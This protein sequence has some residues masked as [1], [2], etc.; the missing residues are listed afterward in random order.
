M[1]LGRQFLSYRF[2]TKSGLCFVRCCKAS[3][4]DV[5]V[6]QADDGDRII[7]T[8]FDNN[9]VVVYICGSSRTRIR[10]HAHKDEHMKPTPSHNCTPVTSNYVNKGVFMNYML[11]ILVNT[12]DFNALDNW[13]TLTFISPYE[14]VVAMNAC[15]LTL[16]FLLYIKFKITL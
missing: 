3:L 15:L 5:W 1:K 6:G 11:D 16:L 9:W 2:A 10:L 8:L 4:F 12:G 14:S 13:N 7:N